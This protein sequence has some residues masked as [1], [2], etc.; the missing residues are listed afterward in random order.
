[1]AKGRLTPI[2]R[3]IHRLAGATSPDA[4]SDGQLLERFVLYR[5]EAAF[6]LLVQRHGPLVWH[7]CQQVLRHA[8][9]AEDAFQATF[10]VLARKAGSVRKQESVGSWLY[11]VAS[12]LARKARVSIERRAA[13]ERQAVDMPAPAARGEGSWGEVERI[14]E[15]ET[16][17]LPAKCREPFVLCYLEGKTNEE[18]ARLLGWPPGTVKTRLAQAREL[19]RKRL[20]RR[21]LTLSTGLVAAV[22]AQGGASAVPAALATATVQAAM[23][24]TDGCAV[25]AGGCTAKAA[26]LAKAALKGTSLVRWPFVTALILTAGLL[27]TGAGL[28][29]YHK[30]KADPAVTRQP[31]E[32]NGKDEKADAR[33][34]ELDGHHVDPHG[35]P[36]PDGAVA[37]LGTVRFRHGG[38]VNAIAFSPN[39][40]LLASASNDQTVRLWETTTGKEIRRIHCER[41]GSGYAVAAVA[42]SPDGKTLAWWGEDKILRLSEVSTGKEIRQFQGRHQEEH[43]AGLLFSPDGQL[44]IDAGTPGVN[45]IRVWDP[46]TGKFVR[47]LAGV[48]AAFSPDGKA[49]ATVEHGTIVLWEVATWK[50]LLH[51]DK[52]L[53]GVLCSVA[54]APDGK[55]L[56]SVEECQDWKGNFWGVARLWDP[57]TGKQLRKFAGRTSV[58]FSPDSRMLA[59]WTNDG[60]VLLV[61][62]ATGKE[63]RRLKTNLDYIQNRALAFSRDGKALAAVE[64]HAIRLWDP[65]TG[66]ELQPSG[67]HR[68]VVTHVAY[69]PDGKRLVSVSE[70]VCVWDPASMTE[71]RRLDGLVESNAT[72]LCQDGKTLASAGSGYRIRLWDVATRKELHQFKH[73]ECAYKVALSPDGKILAA[74]DDLGKI[75]LW[76]V[77]NRKELP[78]LDARHLSFRQLVFSPDGK[79][80]AGGGY[81]APVPLFDVTTGK[82]IGTLGENSEGVNLAFSPDGK[83]LAGSGLD[84]R[85]R[86][87]NVAFGKE[88]RRLEKQPGSSKPTLP[89]LLKDSVGLRR[90]EKQPGS[91]NAIAFSPD[92]RMLAMAYED[93]VRLWEMATGQEVCR[94]QGHQGQVATVAFSPGGRT[95]VSAGFD[96][97]V[98]LWDV[99]GRLRG[100]RLQAVELSP[101]ELDDAW[102]ALAGT[103]AAKA[104]QAIWALV[105][106]PKQSVPFLQEHL[107]TTFDPQRLDKLLRDLDDDTFAVREA[108]SQELEKLG[109]Q[110]VPALRKALASQPSVEVRRR[111]ELLLDKVE[112][113]DLPPATMRALRA[114][115]VLEYVG[116]PEASRL[117]EVLSKGGA[118]APKTR[119][120]KAA[121]ERLAK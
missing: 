81:S 17:R 107:K 36:L 32:P 101:K 74:A 112:K 40:Q 108:A 121:L 85:V 71:L 98:L 3:H 26:T 53:E 11:G 117:L 39:S 50:E 75:K 24:F 14:V 72:A 106:A 57:A 77:E 116:T 61:D 35:D 109:E 120:A 105:A 84:G 47:E 76:D 22:L 79:T 25:A 111:V 102:H 67:G 93:E 87:W 23:G 49:L 20:A 114:I 69:S 37:R 83:I 28:T 31:E 88:L 29:Y 1:M 52:E 115:Q 104:R 78:S 66:K 18:A 16:Q 5:E 63:L 8:Q 58:A 51:W 48:A 38:F 97:T 65:A 4:L 94:F 91:I 34:P 15:E 92:G 7:L 62:P 9:D 43:I 6:E 19:L 80:L 46:A 54:F 110:A 21:G 119:E 44:L 30:T 89:L 2:L 45:K 10:L 68:D 95:L 86:F 64:N 56:A 12:R 33:G 118:E 13:R 96:T 103:D 100:G 70:S 73:R 99:T 41:N 113:A 27:G 90:L 42:I 60:M 82:Q 59:T 55:T